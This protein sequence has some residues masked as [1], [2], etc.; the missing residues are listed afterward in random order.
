MG[1]SGP[2]LKHMNNLILTIA[3]LV[4]KMLKKRNLEAGKKLH[5]ETHANYRIYKNL[6]V[7]K[8]NTASLED[9][10]SL[11]NTILEGVQKEAEDKVPKAVEILKDKTNIFD[12]FRDKIFRTSINPVEEDVRRL[13]EKIEWD[14]QK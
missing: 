4:I 2:P 13:K 12:K 3:E 6:E 8:K 14:S 1:G 5:E 7:I 11:A 10:L 9:K